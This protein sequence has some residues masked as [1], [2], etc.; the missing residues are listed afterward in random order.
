MV[1]EME[2]SSEKVCVDETHRQE[3]LDF[4]RA[5]F[6]GLKQEFGDYDWSRMFTATTIHKKYEFT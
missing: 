1:I 4:G 2:M 6:V 3:R 5:D